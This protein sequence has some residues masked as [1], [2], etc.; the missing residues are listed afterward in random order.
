MKNGNRVKSDKKFAL[1][2]FFSGKTPFQEFNQKFNASVGNPQNQSIFRSKKKKEYSD[3]NFKVS[4]EEIYIN[5]CMI[6]KNF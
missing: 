1:L 4:S 5:I 3:S 6:V 2:Q